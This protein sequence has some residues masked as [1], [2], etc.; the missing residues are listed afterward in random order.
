MLLSK[1]ISSINVIDTI[2]FKDT[3]IVNIE[4]DSREIKSAYLFFAN[5]GRSYVENNFNP[6]DG[7][8]YLIDA[9]NNGA[10]AFVVNKE[11]I[12]NIDNLET[13]K[14]VYDFLKEKKQ[15]IIVV[16]DTVLELA[17]AAAL[18]YNYPSRSLNVIGITGTNGKTSTTYILEYLFKTANI[19]P[20]VVGSISYRYNDKII[21]N[22]EYT[23]PKSLYFQKIMNT[24]LEE[25]VSHF[26]SEVSSHGID[27]DRINNI[28]FDVAIFTNLSRDHLE[29]H[30][31]MDNY[32]NVKKRFFTEFLL[33]SCKKNKYALVNID[34][35]YGKKLY[36]ILKLIKEIKTVSY[37]FNEAAAYSV[38]AYS[39][40]GVGSNFTVNFENNF[41]KDFRIN[42]VGKHN[43]Y[44]ALVSIITSNVI[45]G[46][47]T[48]LI[49]K[50]LLNFNLI[51][52][53]IEPV[54][55]G[56]NVFVDFAHTDDALSNVLL[57]LRNSF[58][59]K[60]IITIFG[61]GGNRDKGKR[62]KMGRVVSDLSDY[63]YITSDNPRFEDPLKIIE[64]I[65]AGVKKGSYEVVVD[66]KE[67]FEKALN[68]FNNNKDVLLIAGKGHEAYQEIQGNKY[69]FND[70]EILKDI[71]IKKFIK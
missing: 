39:L 33:N 38:K 60:K 71:L 52:G 27:M 61:C 51:P 31:T 70:R 68:N 9:Y 67:A 13:Y 12:Y 46:I 56:Y 49:Y 6:D 4:Y 40:N 47:D 22:I 50:A 8:K 21:E 44:N 65:S 1:I 41:T 64:S 59:D 63:T 69:Y 28:D 10:I 24:M 66:R 29:Y 58:P 15:T 43:I 11:F 23:T 48:D 30:Q 55:E 34:C 17:K 53:R 35:E 54:L 18:F 37:G 45:Y 32:F 3:D 5:K 7:H 62:P 16:E 19:K 26:I 42:L 36:E 14:K 2:N 25:K 20:G 57:S